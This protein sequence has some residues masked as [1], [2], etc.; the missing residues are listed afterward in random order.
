MKERVRPRT[1]T[2]RRTPDPNGNSGL[3]SQSN[4]APFTCRISKSC[5]RPPEFIPS[6]PITSQNS[7][8]EIE[9]DGDNVCQRRKPGH[10][11]RSEDAVQEWD[12]DSVSS[13]KR[14]TSYLGL[15]QPDLQFWFKKLG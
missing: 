4:S 8:E 15:N 7:G 1:D 9:L 13:K 6:N 12:G 2:G 11:K 5:P 10:G 3:S 14:A